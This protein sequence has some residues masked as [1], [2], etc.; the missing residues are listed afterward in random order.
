MTARVS[1][2]DAIELYFEGQ[3]VGAVAFP[4][5]SIQPYQT[6]ITVQSEIRFSDAITS[7]ST[8][9]LA[10]PG[11][12]LTFK[13]SNMVI[14][15]FGITLIGNS[16]TKTIMLAGFD[17][18]KG[19]ISL[20]SFDLPSSDDQGIT[21]I[22]NAS[23]KN[24]SQVGL[25]LGSLS[26]GYGSQGV[27][28][29][30]IG[31]IQGQS[32]SLAPL[33][34]SKIQ[35]SGHLTHQDDG[36]SG[37][38]VLNDVVNRFLD[39]QTNVITAT[40]LQAGPPEATWLQDTIKT[41]NV[42][43]NLDS[44]P[45]DNIVNK[46]RITEG[47]AIAFAQEQGVV[48]QSVKAQAD[49][50]LPYLFPLQVQHLDQQTTLEPL[51]KGQ[52]AGQISLVG[53]EIATS[54][55]SA[56][57]VIVDLI[58]T[59]LH[60]DDEQLSVFANNLVPD[61]L[62]D[63]TISLGI[64]GNASAT[65][66]TAAGN[67]DIRSLSFAL[68]PAF[69]LTSLRALNS[70]PPR[71]SSIDVISGT[72]SY[73]QAKATAMVYNPSSITASVGGAITLDILFG[74]H[75]IGQAVINDVILVPGNNTVNVTVQLKLN[76]DAGRLLVQKYT[77]GEA[78]IQIGATGSS[79]STRNK[80][81]EPALAKFNL[82][83]AIPVL[84]ENL[85]T[86]A[87]LLVP[88]D[89]NGKLAV[90]ATFDLKNPFT[91]PISAKHAVASVKSTS[92]FVLANVDTKISITAPGKSTVTSTTF[93]VTLTQDIAG[94]V[95][96]FIGQA[97]I[98]STSIAPLLPLLHTLQAKGSLA[99]TVEFSW[100]GNA[101]CPSS[102]TTFDVLGQVV[103]V[104]QS[105]NVSVDAMADATVGDY[106]IDK[107]AITQNN[108]PIAVDNTVQRLIGP[109]AAPIVESIAAAVSVSVHSIKASRLTSSNIDIQ[110]TI[111][112]TG[113]GPFAARIEAEDM[114]DLM[115][116]DKKVAQLELP[117]F[118]FTGDNVALTLPLR[119][120]V[121]D[122]NAFSDLVNDIVHQP[123]VTL[124]VQSKSLRA[125]AYGFTFS[126]ISVNTRFTISGLSGIPGVTVPTVDVTGETSNSLTVLADAQVPISAPLSVD[127]P[128]LTFAFAYEQQ[129]LGIADV[130]LV[131]LSASAVTPIV[132]KGIVSHL[133]SSAQTTAL[134]HIA[135]RFIAGKTTTGV[136]VHGL[137]ARDDKGKEIPWLSKAI[138]SL[139]LAVDIPG[140]QNLSIVRSIGVPD[141]IA[142][143]RGEPSALVSERMKLPHQCL[144]RQYV[145]VCLPLV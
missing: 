139:G 130:G 100:G 8:S 58:N 3:L 125:I 127:L 72:K 116:N 63:S 109:F 132:A 129:T 114:F 80:L 140:K 66:S 131:S 73:V 15:A 104:L 121:T 87:R 18:L 134:S 137:K 46:I 115:Y 94:L 13:A 128:S 30:Q 29:G 105:I 98:T 99:S 43:V 56:R 38:V 144:T 44:R 45:L 106:S 108:I 118:C 136:M 51:Y 34:V 57:S 4:T 37:L 112:I 17:G 110:V 49:I 70:L 103:K 123:E 135:S 64:H 61:A 65:V 36:T 88:E 10:L 62:L 19:M 12:A 31:L 5:V 25:S 11:V 78:D 26:V 85:V 6:E 7:F 83:A 126:K 138:A 111:S 47:L 133:D 113:V 91:A 124:A 9:L 41:L 48:L 86:G 119:L 2:P 97:E 42:D 60:F 59:G 16:L 67:L 120:A 50:N 81:L 95:T 71:A 96:F 74:R 27:R 69:D 23:V 107:V 76:N 22:A 52:G 40:G 143:L 35:V 28:L 82:E 14:E 24:P 75:P 141:L 79:S 33:G 90:Q 55:L 1:F 102:P 32:V 20:D 122:Q 21:L 93:D 89:V 53:A 84:A 92:Q 101:D 117:P 39:M 68:D 54:M 145:V 77:T 142:D